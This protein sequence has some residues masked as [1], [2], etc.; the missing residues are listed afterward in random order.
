MINPF[1]GQS[2]TQLETWLAE[3]QKDL[4]QGKTT[5]YAMGGDVSKSSAI[6]M[7]PMQRIQKLLEALHV[8]DPDTYPAS[9]IRRVSRTRISV[10]GTTDQTS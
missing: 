6:Q 4:A 9:S 1:I 10:Y 3:A 8:L 7:T 5:S 2:Q